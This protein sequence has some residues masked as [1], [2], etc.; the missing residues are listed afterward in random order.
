M[1]KSWPVSSYNI[2][3]VVEF[4]VPLF[5]LSDIIFL[6]QMQDNTPSGLYYKKKLTFMVYWITNVYDLY[7]VKYIS[8]SINLKGEFFLYLNNICIG[9]N[10]ISDLFISNSDIVLEMIS[11]WTTFLCKWIAWI[12]EAINQIRKWKSYVVVF[13]FFQFYMRWWKW[14]L[15]LTFGDR[16]ARELTCKENHNFASPIGLFWSFSGLS[17]ANM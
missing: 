16:M 13:S 7:Y 14:D 11:Q 9:G 15:N 8:Y 17:S 5:V 2:L 3:V 10:R 12:M 6:N 4:C 1:R